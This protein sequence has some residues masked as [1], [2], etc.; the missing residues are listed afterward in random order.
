MMKECTEGCADDHDRC[1]LGFVCKS[2]SQASAVSPV[3]YRCFPGCSDREQGKQ[4]VAMVKKICFLYN[5]IFCR[6]SIGYKCDVE[7]DSCIE[8]CETDDNC[9]GVKTCS[10]LGIC[11]MVCADDGDCQPGAHCGETLVCQEG[12]VQRPTT[13]DVNSTTS[14][15][16][17]TDTS[18]VLSTGEQ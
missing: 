11:Q 9:P 16:Q 17:S 12:T 2:N 1:P 10:A 14:P 6:C 15:I 5:C 13:E 3:Q 7:S 4:W 18:P 8:G